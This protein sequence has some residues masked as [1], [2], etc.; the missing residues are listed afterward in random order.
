MSNFEG[1]S[2]SSFL[3]ICIIRR[4]LMVAVGT[5]LLISSIF[6]LVKTSSPPDVGYKFWGLRRLMPFV[7]NIFLGYLE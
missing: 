5:S 4:Y 7:G 2:M 3:D 1:F 6:V